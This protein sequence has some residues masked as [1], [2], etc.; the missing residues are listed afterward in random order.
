MS[1]RIR[2]LVIRATTA[3]GVFGTDIVLP[4]G[5]VLIRGEN[6]SGKST[7][8]KA[9][10]YALGLERMFGPANTH[11]LA[12][13][14]S[15]AI[16]EGSTEHPVLH[17]E[18]LLE[19]E[20]A[21]KEAITLQRPIKGANKDWRLVTVWD[22]KAIDNN[23]DLVRRDYFARDPGSATREAGLHRRLSTF[24]GWELPEVLRYDGT[25][26]PLY[27]ECVLPLFYVEQRHGWSSIQASTPRFLQ[28]R[29]IE[30]KAIEFLLNF[31]ACEK[32]TARQRLV[33]EESRIRGEWRTAVEE[34]RLL[35][36]S[37]G[38]AVRCLPK[39]PSEFDS[40][41]PTLLE[42]QLPNGVMTLEGALI[43][44]TRLLHDLESELIPN[45]D[46]AAKELEEVVQ[47]LTRE[48]VKVEQTQVELSDEIGANEAEVS[49]L[50][51][52]LEAL[53]EDLRK[54]QDILKLQGFGGVGTHLHKGECPTCH[55]HVNSGLLDQ[56]AP[57]ELMT[58]EENVEYIRSQI[59][60]FTRMRSRLE[61]RLEA[62]SR[63]LD[64][65]LSHAAEMRDQIRL[66]KRTLI[67]DGRIP[68]LAAIR[69][70]IVV[71]QRIR[72][73]NALIE[74]FRAKVGGFEHLAVQWNDVLLRKRELGAQGLSA[75]DMNK[76]IQLEKVFLR[77]EA[78]FGFNSFSIN[79]L[80]ISKD[81][82]RPNR[83]G[84][85]LVYD[86][87]ASDNIRTICAYLL[88]AL[89][90]SRTLESNHPGILIL[91]EP[92]QQNLQWNNFSVVLAEAANAKRYGQQVIVAT[93][94]SF[95]DVERIRQRTGCVVVHFPGEKI[96]TRLS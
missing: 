90:I 77:L 56:T 26:V 44:D 11:P 69:E 28:I 93:S 70:R 87:S 9:I 4:D 91:D 19:V 24:I 64:A 53:S 33:D 89:E 55:Q 51:S 48:L 50:D 3:A 82:Y 84:F 68:S 73:R 60:T 67:S 71:D 29:D 32:E 30:K 54:N 31:D 86:V 1:I 72:Q 22:G 76:L 13:A 88:A 21:R 75:G 12:P 49:S 59:Q 38:C 85:D 92:R 41:T 15:L 80:A 14:L 35:A 43:Q 45:T 57:E 52:R 7:C 66:A 36:A 39:D 47:R 65:L 25:P 63:R 2:R 62:L 40:N 23:T 46:E 58:V 37:G 27:M 18:V 16:E 74:N 79:R 96:L 83:E 6:S 10:I 95:E 5:L 94:D 17:S 34:C 61:G 42:L 20:N 81:T 78:A 8:L